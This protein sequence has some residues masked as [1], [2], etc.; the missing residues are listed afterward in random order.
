MRKH[1]QKRPEREIGLQERLVSLGLKLVSS[2]VKIVVCKDVQ[3][4]IKRFYLGCDDNFSYKL[5]VQ[6][7]LYDNFFHESARSKSADV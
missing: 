6:D 1:Y 2:A 7:D 4:I 5:K 3:V